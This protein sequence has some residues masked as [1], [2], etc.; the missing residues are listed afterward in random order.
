MISPTILLPAPGRSTV[1]NDEG[2]VSG[3][4]GEVMIGKVKIRWV[5]NIIEEG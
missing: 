3:G 2:V 5:D 4:R 1:A